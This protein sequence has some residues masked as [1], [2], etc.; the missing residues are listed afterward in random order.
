MQFTLACSPFRSRGDRHVSVYRG[1]RRRF[2]CGPWDDCAGGPV[3][4]DITAIPG[5]GL[6]GDLL[7]SLGRRP[8]NNPLSTAVQRLLWQITQVIGLRL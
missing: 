8:L 4:V 1:Q 7:C 6:L 2:E 5:G 3:T